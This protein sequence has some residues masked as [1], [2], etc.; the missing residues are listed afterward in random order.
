MQD[1]TAKKMSCGVDTSGVTLSHAD[2]FQPTVAR[3][4]VPS[5]SFKGV[6]PQESKCTVFASQPAPAKSQSAPQKASPEKKSSGSQA[7][8]DPTSAAGGSAETIELRQQQ[9]RKWIND[10]RTRY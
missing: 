10:W 7:K 9:A 8:V 4:P 1:S 6:M 3:S 2:C 5:V